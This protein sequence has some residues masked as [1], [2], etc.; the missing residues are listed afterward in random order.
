MSDSLFWHVVAVGA[1]GLLAVIAVLQVVHL[2][3]R[4][5]VLPPQPEGRSSKSSV[6]ADATL[7]AF[8]AIAGRYQTYLD[9]ERPDDELLQTENFKE[10]PIQVREFSEDML[11]LS[12]EVPEIHEEGVD[13]P[14][15]LW[16]D[17]MKAWCAAGADFQ[18]DLA[19]HYE[20]KH[21][22][23]GDQTILRWV[24][25]TAIGTVGYDPLIKVREFRHAGGQ[26]DAEKME[27][28]ARK[29]KLLSQRDAFLAE[30][31]RLGAIY[32][33]RWNREVPEVGEEEEPEESEGEQQAS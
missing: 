31:N 22:Y 1:L 14:L 17:K 29:E 4:Q 15:R 16:A 18:A 3:R 2:R 33:K 28:D 26:F 20:R 9:F 6:D 11:S 25:D 13:P 10:F 21:A 7:A 8:N 24:M 32:A 27:L 12:D 30:L 19:A 23:Y 5:D